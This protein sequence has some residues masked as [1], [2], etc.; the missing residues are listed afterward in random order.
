LWHYQGY[1]LLKSYFFSYVQ[2]SPVCIQALSI[3]LGVE[4]IKE[5]GILQYRNS[6][7]VSRFSRILIILNIPLQLAHFLLY[8]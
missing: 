2:T 5:R 4:G 7:I 3:L 1:L 8:Y 6:I